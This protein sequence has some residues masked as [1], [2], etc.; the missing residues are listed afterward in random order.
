MGLAI[1]QGEL[2]ISDTFNHLVRIAQIQLVS[3]VPGDVY[4]K[5]EVGG[6]SLV[7]S[8]V[9]VLPA[10]VLE[11]AVSNSGVK[12]ILG[13]LAGVRGAAGVRALV[14]YDPSF[15]TFTHSEPVGALV[16]GVPLVLTP[17]P[18][19]VEIHVAI[20]GGTIPSDG[21]RLGVLH[22]ETRIQGQTTV[23]LVEGDYGTQM[24]IFQFGIGEKTG[25]VEIG[26]SSRFQDLL[27]FND[28]FGKSRGHA[29]FDT[30]WDLDGDG[31]VGF[32]DFLLWLE[33]Q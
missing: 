21:G 20:L 4:V 13:A 5:T 19:K 15:L 6:F 3:T 1:W 33:Q 17:E 23:S 31:V 7:Q 10:L 8:R 32:T 30:V 16:E 24:G 9:K 2:Y 27:S 14:T 28:A 25:Q 26:Q 12:V 29:D 18:G 11:P 22:F